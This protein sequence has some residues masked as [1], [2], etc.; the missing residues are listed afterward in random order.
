MD[1]NSI[2]PV[3]AIE[4]KARLSDDQ[5]QALGRESCH[6][7]EQWDLLLFK[8]GKLWRHA[9]DPNGANDTLQ[10]VVRATHRSE[11]LTQLQDRRKC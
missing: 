11:I 9:T 3:F 2:C 5:L 6:F 10:L 7:H 8:H 1:D 4:Q